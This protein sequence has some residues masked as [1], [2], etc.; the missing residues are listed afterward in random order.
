MCQVVE[1]RNACEGDDE[2]LY[3]IPTLSRRGRD[4]GYF[5]ISIPSGSDYLYV[6]ALDISSLLR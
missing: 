1:T 2:V 5:S 3:S 4:A 6:E